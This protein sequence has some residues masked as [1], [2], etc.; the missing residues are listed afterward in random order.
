MSKI[1]ADIKAKADELRKQLNY[2]NYRYYVLDS[3]EISD[4][5]Y[6]RL[7]RELTGLEKQYPELITSDSPTQRVGAPVQDTFKTI[8]HTLPMLSLENA[9]E[10]SEFKEW[11][12]RLGIMAELS[13]EPKIDGTAVELVYK[14]G[15]FISGSTRGDGKTGEDITLNLKTIKSVPLRLMGDRIPEYLE[16]RGEVFLPKEPFN[17]LNRQ[18]IEA[19]EEPFANPRNAAAGSLRQL[20]SQITAQ[21]P[22]DILIHGFGQVK[23]VALKTHSEAMEYFTKLRLKAIKPVLVSSLSGAEKYFSEMA[24]RRNDLAF[25]IDGI[26]V[27]V[28][29][30]RVQEQLG[31]RARS[32]RWAI[33]WKFPAQEATTQL[34]DIVVQVGRTGILT[35]VAVLQPVQVGGVEVSRATLHNAEEIERLD[36]KINDWVVLKRAGDVIPKII[37]PV[38]SKRTGKEYQFKMPKECPDCGSKVIQE[39]GEVAFR[40]PNISC[41]AQVKAGIGHFA[42]RDAMNIEGLGDRL[43][44]QLID[45]DII[46]DAADLYTLE[47]KDILKLDRMGD[48]LA[49]NILDAIGRSKKTTLARLIYALG[50]RHIG[51]AIAKT[52]AD[53]FKDIDELS[54][55]SEETLQEIEEIGPVVAQS[56]MQFF[57]NPNNQ[58]VIRKLKE[59]DINPQSGGKKKGGKLEGKVFVFTG[60]MAK[61]SRAEAKQ[62]VEELGAKTSENV[63]KKVDYLVVGANPGSKLQQAQ[64]LGVKIINDEEGFIELLG[65]K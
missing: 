12:E 11:Y 46:K 57:D 47:K 7:L 20:D 45:K 19:D 24:A 8:E 33:A 4:A 25:E 28:D 21:R 49:Q 30:L 35:P 63:S 59:A 6:D 40:C 29:D 14:N 31:L 60:E 62:I 58:L 61:Y 54:Q 15:V 52:L 41:P 13:C 53:N 43:I 42:Q 56:I 50:I 16:V 39:E 34:L 32:P 51:E 44:E 5:E 10:E 27:K 9:M 65:V 26:V 2:H 17:K 48:K 64:K 36:L 37:K 3:P 18:R 22:L 1:T 23:G 55:A 38:L